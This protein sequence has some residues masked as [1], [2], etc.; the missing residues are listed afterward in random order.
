MRA[1]Q[2]RDSI[3][4]LNNVTLTQPNA[5][6][7]PYCSCI[8]HQDSTLRRVSNDQTKFSCLL[9]GR[10]VERDLR[11]VQLLHHGWDHHRHL[12]KK[13]SGQICDDDQRAAATLL[14]DLDDERRDPRSTM[15]GSRSN[16]K[17]WTSDGLMPPPHTWY[18]RF[19]LSLILSIAR[20][21]CSP[22]QP[23]DSGRF[24]QTSS[25]QE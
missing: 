6:V 7:F 4:F 14:R 23:Y 18:V 11:S 13:R 12:P 2:E 17:G 20:S 9:A 24:A 8:Q 25:S 21:Y 3:R 19:L 16:T 15:S 1:I 5:L 10:M 22:V